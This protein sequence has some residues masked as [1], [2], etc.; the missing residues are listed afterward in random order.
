MLKWNSWERKLRNKHL[1][2][3]DGDDEF[4]ERNI[5]EKLWKWNSWERKLGNKHLGGR[6]REDEFKER[7]LGNEI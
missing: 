4:K 1:G 5:V 2:G 3:R 7:H 6:P